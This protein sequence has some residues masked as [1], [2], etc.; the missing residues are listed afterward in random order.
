MERN[1][2]QHHTKDA[3]MQKENCN[4]EEHNKLIRNPLGGRSSLC[5]LHHSSPMQLH[6][7]KTTPATTNNADRAAVSSTKGI[8]ENRSVS[9]HS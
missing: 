4:G 2:I 3:A 6:Y 7:I 1:L 8:S 5:S 9:T